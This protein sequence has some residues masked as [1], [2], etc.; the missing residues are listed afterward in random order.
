VPRWDWH[1]SKAS[2]GVGG[3]SN[4]LSPNSLENR[5]ASVGVCYDCIR[6]LRGGW[7]GLHGIGEL[8]MLLELTVF[9]G[10]L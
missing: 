4:V 6:L 7:E 8:V 5:D 2:G 1:C 9:L 10:W 3:R